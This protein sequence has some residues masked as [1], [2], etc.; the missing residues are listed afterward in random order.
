VNENKIQTHDGFQVKYAVSE[1]NADKPWLAL[2][3]PFGLQVMM[4]K[5]FFDFFESD[6]NVV[7]CESRSILEQ[8]NRKVSEN[9]F[10]VEN[11]VKDMHS[12]LKACNIEQCVLVGYC[13]GAGLALAAANEYPD[14]FTNL[15]LVHGDYMMLN[16]SECITQ[17]AVEI[18]S[19]LGLAGKD[20]TLLGL[21]FEKV[22]KSRTSDNSDRPDGV[23]LAFSELA[24]L[25]R[26][27]ANYLEYKDT[28]YEK[29]AK[30]VPHKTLL[31]TG[32]KDITT[33]VNSTK[34][35]GDLIENS[36]IYIDP[37]ADHYGLLREE[38][39]SMMIIRKFLNGG[40]VANG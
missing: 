7:V 8:S 15:V 6:F 31:M 18:D 5:H 11:H 4:A 22:K 12:V 9:E 26:Y 39:N 32:N 27:A 37:D 28:D 33:N 21:V 23:D 34:K 17:F 13:S 25:R 10:T 24:Y 29:L 1:I 35:I 2:V 36:E 3:I 14:L 30:T 16:D 20:E 40:E 19:V 38:S